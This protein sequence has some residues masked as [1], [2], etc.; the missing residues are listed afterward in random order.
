MCKR[1]DEDCAAG[2]GLESLTKTAA[3]LKSMGADG[4]IVQTD[5]SLLV[6][7][8]NLAEKSFEA[9]GEVHLLVNNAGVAVLGSVLGSSMD[10]WNWQ[11][12][13]NFYGVLYGI[14]AFIPRMIE[15]DTVSHVV[16]VAGLSGVIEGEGPYDVSKHAV[17]AL[18]ESLYH[19]LADNAPQ[20]KVSVYCP[21]WV[22]TEID[23][24]DRSRPERFKN[25]A[26]LLT[27]E[28]R[29]NWR[30]V[31]A[32]GFSIEESAR[33]LFEGLQNDSLYIGPKA[34]QNQLPGLVDV[35]RNRAE[36]ILNERN[37]EHPVPL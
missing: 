15:Q 8:E 37:P 3:D 21:G 31:L 18:T 2:I 9:F 32:S 11:M 29:A 35:V 30:E 6:D 26:T 12:D 16:N 22:D 23:R 19:E 24:I 20:I 27:E 28:E 14:R 34:F 4:L 17:V 10:D 36:N 33:V 25:D 1:G 13:V 5:V 7:V